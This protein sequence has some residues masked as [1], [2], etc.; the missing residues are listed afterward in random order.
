MGAGAVRGC[1]FG[2]VAGRS[3]APPS[4]LASLAPARV[5]SAHLEAAGVTD[6][7]GHGLAVTVE[8]RR[9][10]RAAQ[11]L[12][13][14]LAEAAGRLAGDRQLAHLAVGH[15]ARPHHRLAGDAL[16][17]RLLRV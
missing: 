12:A 8:R 4:Y 5:T 15:D 16:L 1:G 11:G 6:V 9:P 7:R 13:A 2:A 3:M 14:R 10:A 17:A